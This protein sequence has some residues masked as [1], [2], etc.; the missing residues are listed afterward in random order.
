MA[1]SALAATFSTAVRTACASPRMARPRGQ[2]MSSVARVA[3]SVGFSRGRSL[4]GLMQ[5]ARPLPV[6]QRARE[7]NASQ[8]GSQPVHEDDDPERRTLRQMLGGHDV[9]EAREQKPDEKPDDDNGY[10]TNPGE[11]LRSL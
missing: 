3:T 9:V 5:P 8:R 11:H 10:G 6:Q 2:S 7:E 1:S 4:L